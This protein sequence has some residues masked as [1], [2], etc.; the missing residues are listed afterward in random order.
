[1]RKFTAQPMHFHGSFRLE[2]LT[3][4][5]KRRKGVKNKLDP[6]TSEPIRRFISRDKPRCFRDHCKL[7]Y[8]PMSP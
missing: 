7:F 2:I 4:G 1:M 8:K 6:R 3:V 5:A